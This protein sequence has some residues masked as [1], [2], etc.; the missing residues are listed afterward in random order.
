[1]SVASSTENLTTPTDLDALDFDPACEVT[2]Y[3]YDG[4]VKRRCE[5][6]AAWIGIPPCGHEGYFCEHHRRHQGLQ[7]KCL[8]CGARNMRMADYRWIPL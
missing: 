8:K 5:D 2:Y 3:G 1:V 6:V 7:W 4:K